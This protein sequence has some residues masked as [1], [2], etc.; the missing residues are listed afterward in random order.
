MFC[1]F[2]VCSCPDFSQEDAAVC[3][4]TRPMHSNSILQRDRI[5][6]LMM[7]RPQWEYILTM[8]G[9]D[10]TKLGQIWR[11]ARVLL[12]CVPEKKIRC[13]KPSSKV[14]LIQSSNVHMTDDNMIY[15]YLHFLIFFTQHGFHFLYRGWFSRTS[16]PSGSARTLQYSQAALP[17]CRCISGG[18]VAWIKRTPSNFHTVSYGFDFLY[19]I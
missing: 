3:C 14:D 4:K 9:I 13:Y 16:R 6:V 15:T 19:H 10:C 12:W 17:C 5:R 18:W 1:Y 8:T 2:F 7:V 11:A